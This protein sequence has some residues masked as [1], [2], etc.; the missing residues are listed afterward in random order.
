M[1]ESMD[2]DQQLQI[3]WAAGLYD[4]EGSTG[5]NGRALWLQVK[6]NAVDDGPSDVLIRLAATLGG[7]IGGPYADRP[8]RRGW[9]VHRRPYFTWYVYGA[10][11]QAALELIWPYL[12]SAKRAQ[13][14]L[15]LNAP[16]RYR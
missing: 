8:T 15:A 11:A 12:G 6:Q 2:R 3:A 9:S 1:S 7:R 16:T 14:E 5:L 13:A 10:E 4:G